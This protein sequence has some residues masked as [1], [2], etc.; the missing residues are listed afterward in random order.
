MSAVP[1]YL[2]NVET[3][4]A[5]W[6]LLLF[7]LVSALC[8]S[9]AFG[10]KSYSA[11]YPLVFAL[12]LLG[13][14]IGQ[15]TGL[16]RSAAVGDVLPAVL[17]L[18]GGVLIYLIGTKGERLQA[19]VVMGVVGLTINL[20]VGIYWGAH[21]RMLA[22]ADPGVIAAAAVAEENARHTA[23]IQKLLNELEYAKLKAD[24]DAGA[25]R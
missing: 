8:I 16:S 25:P 6:P 13:I 19:A 4:K 3:W 7:P 9:A 1:D 23:A 17:G 2:T 22:E 18:L 15:I 10:P 21:S 11:S 5:L 12:S 24:L 14:A 20:V